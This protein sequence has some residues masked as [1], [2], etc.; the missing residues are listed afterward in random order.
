MNHLID[1]F[2]RLIN[3]S[4]VASIVILFVL[5]ARLILKRAPKIFSYVLWAIVLIRLLV[6]IHIPSPISAIPVTQTTNSAEINAA[7]PPLDFETPSDRQKNGY[8]LQQS[9]EKDTPYVHV[10]HSLEPTGYLAI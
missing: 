2:P 1:F 8:S 5:A 10:S 3:M 9:I 6:P 7:L 4:V